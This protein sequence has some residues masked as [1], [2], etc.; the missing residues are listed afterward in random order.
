MSWILAL[1]LSMVSE[2]ST[3]R[4]MV[5]PVTAGRGRKI[6]GGSSVE[7]SESECSG[8][9]GAHIGMRQA[10][11]GKQ[12]RNE[13]EGGADRASHDASRPPDVRLTL[14]IDR[15]LEDVKKP[16]VPK[17]EMAAGTRGRRTRWWGTHGS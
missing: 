11:R 10:D 8:R 1:S 5:L 3:S 17:S 7:V 14:E 16:R 6:G 15:R 12:A 9:R 13:S 2:D 4:V